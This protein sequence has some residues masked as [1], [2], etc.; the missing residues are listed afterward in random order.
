MIRTT[1]A[2]LE[3]VEVARV[4]LDHHFGGSLHVGAP[5]LGATAL[6]IQFMEVAASHRRQGIGAPVV[7]RLEDEYPDRRLLALSEGADEFWAS[8]GWERFDYSDGL[9]L[10][11]PLFVQPLDRESFG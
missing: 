2:D 5:E 11:R 10:Y 1:C 9:R 7:E 4:E 6:E 8:L 3:G